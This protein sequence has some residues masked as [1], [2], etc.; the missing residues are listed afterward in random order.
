V[1]RRGRPPEANLVGALVGREVP[2]RIFVMHKFSGKALTVLELVLLALAEPTQ[3][4]LVQGLRTCNSD[5]QCPNIIRCQKV[6]QLFFGSRPACRGGPRAVGGKCVQRDNAWCRVG[7]PLGLGGNCAER[8]C[9]E[10]YEDNDCLNSDSE[11]Y[12]G[13]CNA[14]GI[15]TTDGR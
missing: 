15:S 13:R 7:N 14:G 10:C 3:A 2:P 4:F 11:C 1:W 6:V 12:F 9:L 8:V 5:R